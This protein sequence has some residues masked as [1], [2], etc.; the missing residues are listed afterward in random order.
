[1]ESLIQFQHLQP[2]HFQG[3]TAVW[4]VEL[5]AH[6]TKKLGY[7]L[8]IFTNNQPSSAISAASTL[9]QAKAAELMEEQ[10]WLQQI[11]RISSDKSLFNR[12]LGRAEQ[13]IYLLLQ[14]FGKQSANTSNNN[15]NVIISHLLQID[16]DFF[17]INV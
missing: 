12:V 13:D 4:R 8:N 16:S 1:M 10:K 15:F 9:S 7:R 6:E 11:T 17:I 14:S 2:S 3:Y 5:A